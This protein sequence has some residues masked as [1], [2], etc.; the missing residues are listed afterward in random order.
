MTA[1]PPHSGTKPHCRWARSW[2]TNGVSF[3]E[4][5]RRRP[6]R[7][8]EIVRMIPITAGR[9]VNDIPVRESRAV[10]EMATVQALDAAIS[11]AP[12]GAAP[13]DFVSDSDLGCDRNFQATLLE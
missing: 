1:T 10:D 2:G 5:F 13:Q 6:P 9:D 3:S 12:M 7:I 11:D 4:D 8:G